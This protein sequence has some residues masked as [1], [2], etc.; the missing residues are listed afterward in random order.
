MWT[1]LGKLNDLDPRYLDWL[2]SPNGIEDSEAIEAIKA[3]L[4]QQ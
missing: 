4:N 3:Y 1:S 2:L